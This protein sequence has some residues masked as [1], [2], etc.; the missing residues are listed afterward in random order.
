MANSNSLNFTGMGK[1]TPSKN[2]EWPEIISVSRCNSNFLTNNE[3]WPETFNVN[4]MGYD[5]ASMKIKTA[6]DPKEPKQVTLKEHMSTDDLMD[7]KKTDSFSYYSIPGVRR[8]NLLCQP[9]IDMSNLGTPGLSRR[10]FISCPSRLNDSQL[11]AQPQ[12]VLRKSRL[13][14][15]CHPSVLAENE[16]E[17]DLSTCGEDCKDEHLEENR[18][19][20]DEVFSDPLSSLL[21]SMEHK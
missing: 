18:S 7:I 11:K 16:D 4:I 5:V 19:D 1:T 8:A 3:E 9:D 12:P 21:A 10:G 6:I 2:E 13:S 14:F 17:D 15:E 20:E